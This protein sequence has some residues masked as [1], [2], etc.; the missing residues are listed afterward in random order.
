MFLNQNIKYE[1]NKNYH[2]EKFLKLESKKTKKN[3]SCM[4]NVF[5]NQIL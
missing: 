2:L 3:N 1:S 5:V 4:N